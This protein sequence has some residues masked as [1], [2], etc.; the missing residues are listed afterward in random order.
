MTAAKPNA[1]GAPGY[2]A[3]LPCVPES[4]SRARAL[5]SSALVAWGMG[6]DLGDC[7]EIIVSELL[8]NA[9]DHTET[10][11]T[12][13][14]IER[15]VDSSVR[16]GVSDRSQVAPRMKKAT[17]DTECGRGLHLVHALSWRWGYDTHH[18]GK[19]TWAV[20]KAPTGTSQ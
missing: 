3:E 1:T 15:R 13:V 9:V 10:P 6:D 5:V 19:V 14:V 17:D 2:T 4:V 18:W 12:Q 8:T 20:I 7:G 16:I 11:L